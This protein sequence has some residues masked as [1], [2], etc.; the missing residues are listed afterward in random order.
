M[1]DN[2]SH[3]TGLF[4]FMYCTE[5]FLQPELLPL[6]AVHF[7]RVGFTLFSG[8]RLTV[9]SVLSHHQSK[10]CS[11]LVSFSHSILHIS[12]R[13]YVIIIVVY[14]CVCLFEYCL[15]TPLYTEHH[16]YRLCA[17][18]STVSCIV[19]STQKVYYKH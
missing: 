1:P 14:L 19:P 3:C 12:F 7:S 11:L 6:P 5:F 9:N 2:L 16:E 10:L 18:F 17:S 8:F 13:A 15:L 4:K